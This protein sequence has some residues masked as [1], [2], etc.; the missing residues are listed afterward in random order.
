M[1]SRRRRSRV[2]RQGAASRLPNSSSAGLA[3]ASERDLR[4]PGVAAH[5]VTMTIGPEEHE[6]VERA[7]ASLGVRP[8]ELLRRLL[9]HSL[10]PDSGARFLELELL[11]QRVSALEDALRY[12]EGHLHEPRDGRA[13]AES[14]R[15]RVNVGRRLRG[16]SVK[17]IDGPPRARLHEEIAAVLRETGRPLGSAEIAQRIRERGKFAPPRS[18]RPVDV[19]MVVSRISHEHYKHMFSRE[20]GLVRLAGANVQ[21]A[22]RRTN[23]RIASVASRSSS[24]A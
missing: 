18:K 3:A 16:R 1:P 9:R 19:L 11:Q 10:G 2:G 12:K 17:T 20:G 21:G 13:Q 8:A 5:R 23:T 22:K 7:A 4:R 15:K 6:S 14:D 24:T